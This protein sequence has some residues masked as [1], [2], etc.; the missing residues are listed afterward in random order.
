M[1]AKGRHNVPSPRVSEP[2]AVHGPVPSAAAPSCSS[3]RRR[4][5]VEVGLVTGIGLS[6][7]RGGC[8]PV[9]T[10]TSAR[11]GAHTVTRLGG[12]TQERCTY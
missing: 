12:D 3:D 5:S 2:E 4:R 1:V 10:L 8:V 11:S 6:G 9:T 7:E